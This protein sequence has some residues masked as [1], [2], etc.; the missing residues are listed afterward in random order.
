MWEIRNIPGYSWP[1]VTFRQKVSSWC[2]IVNKVMAQVNVENGK[3][4]V[5]RTPIG[6]K[7][8]FLHLPLSVRQ[9]IVYITN[10]LIFKKNVLQPFYKEIFSKKIHS[11]NS[12]FAVPFVFRLW[13]T[14]IWCLSLKSKKSKSFNKNISHKFAFLLFS[15]LTF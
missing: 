7:L 8:Q 10:A 6:Q 15:Y 13:V 2:Y 5:H 9:G 4:T 12:E 3:L 1:W 14:V 11:A